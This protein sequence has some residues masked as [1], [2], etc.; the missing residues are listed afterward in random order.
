MVSS[1]TIFFQLFRLELKQ[2]LQPLPNN[3]NQFLGSGNDIRIWLDSWCGQPL[4]PSSCLEFLRT[5]GI[6]ANIIV[7]KFIKDDLQDF[8]HCSNE[9]IPVLSTTIPLT[10]ATSG[11][12]RYS[13]IWNQNESRHF[14]LKDSYNFKT[15]FLPKLSCGDFI[16]SK[17]I[18]PNKSL[19]VWRIMDGKISTD[20][21]VITRGI[22]LP[23][24]YGISNSTIESIPH[25][26]FHCRFSNALWSWL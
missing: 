3:N 13:L 16:L 9:W 25:I 26:F 2:S 15:C 23:S 5:K 4:I 14:T 21:L 12:Y 22:Y 24:R 17:D 20:N 18:P 1:K 19:L 6:K 10:L 7:S 11:T 8:R